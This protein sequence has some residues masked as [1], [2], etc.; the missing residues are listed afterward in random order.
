MFIN[1]AKFKNSEISEAY[2]SELNN[3][4]IYSLTTPNPDKKDSI[5]QKF[6]TQTSTIIVKMLGKLNNYSVPFLQQIFQII[7]N[8]IRPFEDSKKPLKFLY[9]IIA[10]LTKRIET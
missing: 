8:F 6:N 7:K 5:E 1:S 9:Q 10:G 2:Y 4:I 3:I